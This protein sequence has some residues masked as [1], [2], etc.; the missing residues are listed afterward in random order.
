VALAFEAA[1]I[2]KMA[3]KEKQR[4]SASEEVKTEKIQVISGYC[5][6]ARATLKNEKTIRHWCW[7]YLKK[8]AALKSQKI[9]WPEEW[10]DEDT[11]LDL[12]VFL[13]TVDGTHCRILEPY[14]PLY[15]KTHH[16]T[17]TNPRKLA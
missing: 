3:V 13:C 12:P 2:T 11:E 6:P 16:T 10:S 8:I 9:V 1:G 5:T 17:P 15:V 7:Y 14:H 4:A